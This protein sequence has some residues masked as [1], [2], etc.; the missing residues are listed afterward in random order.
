[1]K[2]VVEYNLVDG[3]LRGDKITENVGDGAYSI[4]FNANGT[5]SDQIK[6]TST[7]GETTENGVHTEEGTYSFS[8]GQLTL[9]YNDEDETDIAKATV[10]GNS[11]V[12]VYEDDD[13]TSE[14]TIIEVTEEHYTK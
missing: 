8:N 3:E 6:T 9:K 10:T 13:S 11:L 4:T 12:I 7:D 5:F 14:H 1:M 2:K